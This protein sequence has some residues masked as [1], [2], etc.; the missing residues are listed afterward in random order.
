MKPWLFD[1]LACPIDKHFP[2]KLYIFAYET[3]QSEFEIFLNVYENRDLVQIQ[4]EEII[5]IIEEDEKY[6]IR[7]NII[8]E[9]NLIEDYLNLLLSSINE[10]ENIIDKSPYEFSKK[11]Y[12]LIKTKIKQNII[13]FSHKINI[14]TIE[15]ILPELYFINKIK[16]DIE[17]DSGILLCEQCHR[18]FPIIQTIP[19]M[20]PDEYRDADKELEFLENNKNLLDENFFHQD[21]KP[22]N[23]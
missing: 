14:K 18:W 16:I 6:Y 10:L 3:K 15:Q 20:L 21:L 9:K 4:K 17:I 1:I 5:K 11:C 19:Q 13:E 12:D 7:D 2:L 8:I 23:I 22:F